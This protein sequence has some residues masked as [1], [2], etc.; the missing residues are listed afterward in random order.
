MRFLRILSENGNRTAE[1]SRAV[2]KPGD[3]VEGFEEGEG[4][5]VDEDGVEDGGEG[6]GGGEG[7]T[8]DEDSMPDVVAEPRSYTSQAVN[9]VT[10]GQAR[11]AVASGTLTVPQMQRLLGGPTLTCSRWGIAGFLV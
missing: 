3:S 9:D 11:A 1:R 6:V 8:A 4:K 10:W 5:A 2:D 7:E